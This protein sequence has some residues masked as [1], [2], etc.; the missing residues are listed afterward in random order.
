MDGSKYNK[1]ME[2]LNMFLTPVPFP[3]GPSCDDSAGFISEESNIQSM[4]ENEVLKTHA[5]LHLFH[6]NKCG[7]NLTPKT[8]KKLHDK[9]AEKMNFH[10]SFDKLDE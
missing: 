8:I 10:N 6:N 5:M 1:L 7:K 4:D 3:A 9:C 2:K